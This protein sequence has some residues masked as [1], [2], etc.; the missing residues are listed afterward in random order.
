MIAHLAEYLDKQRKAGVL[1][2]PF[3][4]LLTEND[5]L[6]LA[7][8]EDYL[9]T[10]KEQYLGPS[11]KRL[12]PGVV[13]LEKA[14]VKSFRQLYGFSYEEQAK[15]G[16][17][18]LVDGVSVGTM[19]VLG[20]PLLPP[21]VYYM[22]LGRRRAQDHTVVRSDHYVVDT[23]AYLKGEWAEGWYRLRSVD[24]EIGEPGWL[25]TVSYIRSG[26]TAWGTGWPLAWA[27]NLTV[28]AVTVTPVT[29]PGAEV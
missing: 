15:A 16:C 14:V 29:S 9:T 19:T 11:G 26:R 10:G 18:E 1:G 25:D 22:V 20:S 27:R 24:L 17:N 2:P 7:Q 3:A 6:A 21:G 23:A 13:G 28:E 5:R 8:L 4:P 12:L